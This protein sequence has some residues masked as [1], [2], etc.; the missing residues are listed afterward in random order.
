MLLFV[1]AKP[2]QK[3]YHRSVF[4]THIPLFFFNVGIFDV[5]FQTFG[6]PK[7]CTSGS[8]LFLMSFQV[9]KGDKGRAGGTKGDQGPRRY[10]RGTKGMPRGTEG[11]SRG[12]NV[13]PQMLPRRP[14]STAET[15]PRWPADA[16]CREGRPASQP[17]GQPATHPQSLPRRFRRAIPAAAP[18][19]LPMGRTRGAPR[20]A[21]AVAPRDAPAALPENAP[22]NHQNQRRKTSKTPLKTI[23]SLVPRPAKKN[24]KSN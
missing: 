22:Q 10:Q 21:P 4:G 24:V 18:E 13:H 19:M 12:A 7:F 23:R 16:A 14:A 5:H 3:A 1:T 6:S 2:V 11:R 20:D 17:A 9:F 8:T 15:L